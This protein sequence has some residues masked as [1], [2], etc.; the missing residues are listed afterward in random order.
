LDQAFHQNDVAAILEK[1]FSGPRGYRDDGKKNNDVAAGN[2][3]PLNKGVRYCNSRQTAKCCTSQQNGEWSRR[4]HSIPD[5]VIAF[6]RNGSPR[7][8]LSKL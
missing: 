8:L 2:K 3:T 4:G 1:N 5:D 6:W 7:V